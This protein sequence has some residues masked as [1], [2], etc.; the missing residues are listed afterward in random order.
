MSSYVLSLGSRSALFVERDGIL[1]RNCDNAL[2]PESLSLEDA[3]KD[4]KVERLAHWSVKHAKESQV[5]FLRDCRVRAQAASRILD[6]IECEILARLHIGFTVDSQDY[7]RHFVRD[8]IYT[9][10]EILAVCKVGT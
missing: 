3:T 4:Y 10:E 2:F 9:P 5:E 6:E 7:V 8:R 1:C